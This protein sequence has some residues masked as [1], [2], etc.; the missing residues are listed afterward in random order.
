M[1]KGKE[2]GEKRKGKRE[3]ER[4][5]EMNLKII[6]SEFIACCVFVKK[7][8]NLILYRVI[9]LNMMQFNK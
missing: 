3:K 2:K 6:F 4:S 9:N 5:V 7:F 1:G 8:K